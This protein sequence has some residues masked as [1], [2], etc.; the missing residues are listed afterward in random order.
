M[1]QVIVSNRRLQKTTR[2]FM[3]S[4]DFKKWKYLFPSP[5][6]YYTVSVHCIL[7]I[8]SLFAN[9]KPCLAQAQCPLIENTF[10]LLSLP[11][12]CLSYLGVYK[13]W[14]LLLTWKQ[15]LPSETCK[16]ISFPATDVP[17]CEILLPSLYK[18][19]FMRVDL[20]FT[21]YATYFKIMPSAPTTVSEDSDCS[22]LLRFKKRKRLQ[23]WKKKKK[24]LLLVTQHI[25]TLEQ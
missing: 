18:R 15:D 13:Q 24:R 1:F 4:Q 9:K 11:T 2:K 5:C 20:L 16:K 8:F 17:F 12:V 23:K 10:L 7:S 19:F 14:G 22:L 3:W 6:Q 21:V 25:N